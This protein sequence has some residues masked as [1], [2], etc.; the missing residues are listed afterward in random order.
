MGQKYKR[1]CPPSEIKAPEFEKI[2]EALSDSKQDVTLLEMYY[3]EDVNV[4][5]AARRLEKPNRKGNV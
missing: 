4:V 2:V 3:R 5:P 1:Y